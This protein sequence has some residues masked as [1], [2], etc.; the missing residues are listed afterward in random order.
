[1]PG[2]GG[3]GGDDTIRPAVPGSLPPPPR[4]ASLLWGCMWLEVGVG[5]RHP[6]LHP[7][8][9]AVSKRM[10]L[11]PCLQTH[12]PPPSPLASPEAFGVREGIGELL[13]LGAKFEGVLHLLE[14]VKVS[15]DAKI[16]A[17]LSPIHGR[18]AD[19]RERVSRTQ[20]TLRRRHGGADVLLPR[21]PG[22]GL[23]PRAS[24]P[25]P[26]EGGEQGRGWWRGAPRSPVGAPCVWVSREGG[27]SRGDAPVGWGHMGCSGQGGKH[28][29]PGAHSLVIL[30]ALHVE[31]LEDD[32]GQPRHVAVHGLEAQRVHVGSPRCRLLHWLLGVAG[33]G[34]S[35]LVSLGHGCCRREGCR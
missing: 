7:G 3:G 15:P 24:W 11:A 33:F 29:P 20:P 25:R 18:P 16:A 22:F 35:A 28:A 6:Q 13:A 4:A 17:A 12:T 8:H 27:M 9:R 23:Q 21:L 19:V 32:V 34:G 14:H 31:L 5:A 2:R 1:V 30:V 26:A 10:D